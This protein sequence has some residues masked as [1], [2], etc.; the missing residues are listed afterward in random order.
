MIFYTIRCPEGATT[1]A[2][3]NGILP[4][5][6]ASGLIASLPA[7]FLAI[8][9][10]YDL[11]VSGANDRTYNKVVLPISQD[12]INANAGIRDQQNKGY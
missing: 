4:W 6:N 5:V 3:A 8:F 2:L 9:Q 12:E 11:S 7:R 10:T 1:E